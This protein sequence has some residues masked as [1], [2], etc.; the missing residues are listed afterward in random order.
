MIWTPPETPYNIWQ[1]YNILVDAINERID[2]FI[3]YDKGDSR[4]K[5]YHAESPIEL[6]LGRNELSDRMSHIKSGITHLIRNSLDARQ[7]GSWVDLGNIWYWHTDS[8][9]VV[10][11]ILDSMQIPKEIWFFEKPKRA[12]ELNDFFYCCYRLL[13]E[14]LLFPF[15]P[16]V[17]GGDRDFGIDYTYWEINDRGDIVTYQASSRSGVLSR[18]RVL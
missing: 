4:Y 5:T 6:I 3:Q 17:N 13:N 12:T 14:V 11:D 9:I 10:S 18:A 7:I 1:Y 2:Y 16:R 8:D 15:I